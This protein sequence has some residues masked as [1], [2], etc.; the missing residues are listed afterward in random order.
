MLETAIL[1]ALAGLALAAAASLACVSARRAC[2]RIAAEGRAAASRADLA[3]RDA[4]HRAERLAEVQARHDALDDRLCEAQAERQR[5]AAAEAKLQQSLDGLG[6]MLDEARDE[7]AAIAARLDA[8]AAEISDLK[9]T[10]ER[11]RADFA[12]RAEA[13]DKEVALL[14]GLRAE[15]TDRFK[16]LADETLRTHGESFGRTN[17]E[18]IEALLT[19]VREQVTHFQ[20]ELRAAHEGAAKDRERLK[21][22]IEHLSRRSEEVSREAV[23]LTRA[24]K[25]EKQRQGAWGEMILERLLE[26][27]GLERGREY[28][29]QHAMRGEDGA[30]PRRA[31]VLVA[32]PQDRWLVIDAKVSLVAYEAAVNA[33][34]APAR[35][36]ALAAHARA[37]RAHIDDL[38]RRG[39]QA[40]RPER[41]AGR[42]SVDYVVMFV[43]IE[44]ALAAALSSEGDLTSYAL[45]RGVGIATPMTLML[46]LRTVEHVWSVERRESNAAEIA[47]RGGLLHDKVVGFVEAMEGVGQHLARAQAAHDDAMGRL[48]RGQGNLLRQVQ[49]LK[50]LGADTRKSIPIPFD[51]APGGA[52]EAAE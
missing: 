27:S 1:L 42:G 32:M 49:M 3:E 44:G 28:F 40:L 23:A 5:L 19:P 15:M 48:S 51:G 20:T 13:H 46:A 39:Y 34:E 43:P 18:R 45:S 17:R 12:A 35:D 22:E 52:I 29:V 7:R 2:A 6:T 41:G 21:T 24:L 9:V 16:A 37:V 14:S 30:A 4:A 33:E 36:A 47:R 31:D 10:N 50:D 11:L 26:D 38:A 25:G 8:A